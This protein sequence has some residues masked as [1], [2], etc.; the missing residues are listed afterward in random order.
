[1]KS[2]SNT[3]HSAFRFDAVTKRHRRGTCSKLSRT[4]YKVNACQEQKGTKKAQTKNHDL[5]VSLFISKA[6][7]QEERQ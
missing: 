6:P 5:R 1:M 4:Y 3:G 7:T 2:I